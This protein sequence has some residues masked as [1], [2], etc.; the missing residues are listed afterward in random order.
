MPVRVL[1]KIAR[2]VFVQLEED[3]GPREAMLAYNPVENDE[4]S[5]YQYIKNVTD[6][7]DDLKRAF[8]SKKREVKPDE[9]TTAATTVSYSLKQP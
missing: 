5:L 6:L 9:K 8:G 7:L 1:G 4:V 3:G 2:H